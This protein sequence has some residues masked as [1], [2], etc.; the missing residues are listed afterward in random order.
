M[1]KLLLVFVSAAM[2]AACGNSKKTSEEAQD[3]AEASTEAVT[4]N[5][6]TEASSVHWTGAKVIEGKHTGT[7]KIS[8]GALSF[9]GDVL[10]AGNF[11]IDMNSISNTD[12]QEEEGR[13][14][15][16]GHLKSGDFFLVDSFPTAKFEIS[17]VEVLENSS[18]GTHTITGNLTI[19]GKTNSISFPATITKTADEAAAKA[20][21]EINRNEWNVLWG[22]TKESNPGVI[23]FLKDNLLSDMIAFS[24]DL[25]AGK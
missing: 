5:V 8:E 25:K 12:I 10:T 2:F 3:V 18:E 20:N 24:V 4:L 19:K 22:G 17:K 9:E 1:K 16:V 23:S 14:K 6:N 7:V 11:T 15:L 13:N 21:F